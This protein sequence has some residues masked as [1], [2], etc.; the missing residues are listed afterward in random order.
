MRA[1]DNPQPDIKKIKLPNLFEVKIIRPS[2]KI[3]KAFVRKKIKDFLGVWN[4]R[5]RPGFISHPINFFYQ[6]KERIT[7][8]TSYLLC[9]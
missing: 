8:Q 1:S 3:R 4:K 6:N 5:I 2:I 7:C 9:W